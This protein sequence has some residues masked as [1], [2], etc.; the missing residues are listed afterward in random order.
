MRQKQLVQ[1]VRIGPLLVRYL[2]RIDHAHVPVLLSQA[3]R[4]FIGLAFADLT[5]E[6]ALLLDIFPLAFQ[7]HHQ[8]HRPLLRNSL[9]LAN[10]TNANSQELLSIL[11]RRCHLWPRLYFY[12]VLSTRTRCM[13]E[14]MMRVRRRHIAGGLGV[15][16]HD[17]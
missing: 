1:L 4:L 15:G 14:G 3:H 5:V 7:R 2:H 8:I 9:V 13:V 17:I 12:G 11:I 6:L 16:G 10:E